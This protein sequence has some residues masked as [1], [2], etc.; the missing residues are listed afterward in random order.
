MKRKHHRE[1]RNRVLH[2]AAKILGRDTE[3]LNTKSDVESDGAENDS[4]ML[5]LCAVCMYQEYTL[6][7]L[8]SSKDDSN[9]I[10]VINKR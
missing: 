10:Y 8:P 9:G 7:F 3:G 4:L 6:V 1:L 2:A 5:E